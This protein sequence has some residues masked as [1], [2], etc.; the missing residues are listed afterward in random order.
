MATN[1]IKVAI[2]DPNPLV[3]GDNARPAIIMPA[4]TDTYVDDDGMRR[5]PQGELERHGLVWCEHILCWRLPH[6]D[7]PIY[8][9]HTVGVD[10]A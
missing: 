4:D 6:E 3:L 2:Y 8:P 1:T 10:A 5:V 7:T 9:F